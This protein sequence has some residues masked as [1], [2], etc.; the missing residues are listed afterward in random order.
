VGTDLLSVL[1]GAGC[2]SPSPLSSQRRSS[3][4]RQACPLEPAG[5]SSPT[6]SP[7]MA[8]SGGQTGAS[9][10]T[11]LLLP[12]STALIGALPR[13]SG[14]VGPRGCPSS[15]FPTNTDS[16]VWKDGTGIEIQKLP[17]TRAARRPYRPQPPRKVGL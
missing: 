14:F 4:H 10:T 3:C 16:G 15:T 13:S 11:Y 7:S 2:G 12:A 8:V 6:L 9:E 17:A 5:A 1:A